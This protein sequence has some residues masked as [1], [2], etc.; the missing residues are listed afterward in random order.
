[1]LYKIYDNN[2][3]N[4]KEYNEN[5]KVEKCY[6]IPKNEA[7]KFSDEF[8]LG[9]I[10]EDIDLLYS[11]KEYFTNVE[12]FDLSQCNSEHA[13]HHFFNGIIDG[14]KTCLLLEKIKNT[15]KKNKHNNV[16]VAFNDNASIIEGEYIIDILLNNL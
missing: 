4:N 13:R 3:I 14:D 6:I 1:M 9:F 15:Y 7:L 12:L 11:I 2:E 8:G 5:I 10:I 16:I